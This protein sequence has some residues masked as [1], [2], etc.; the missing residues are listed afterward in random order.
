MTAAS[1]VG[2]PAPPA[3]QPARIQFRRRSVVARMPLRSKVALAVLGLV[4]VAAVCAPVLP[5]D[6]P[7]AGELADRLRNF[8]A[9][10]HPLGTDTQGRDMVSRL[11]Y[12]TRTSLFAGVAP[13]VIA[14]VLGLVWGTL[15]ALA[16]RI[17]NTV[18]MRALDVLFAFPGV[19][20]SL[21]LAIK[22]G[23]GVR[24]L[25][26]ALTLVWIAPVARIAETEVI[27][28][29][30]LD[31]MAAARSSGASFAAIL[32]RQVI[33]VALPAIVAYSTSLVGANIAIT[34]GLG[35]IGLGV[36]TPTPELGSML[37]E[38]QGQIYAHPTLSLAPVVV[39]LALS[40]LFP[41]VGDG[42]RDAI[43]GRGGDS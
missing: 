19:L 41:I 9:P 7:L 8:G 16:G 3:A 10:G 43:A 1:V 31:F 28:I 13:I 35:F 26:I 14:T 11:V 20:L 22:L 38:M 17:V 24:T 15:A 39:V 2:A 34:G 29:K 36:R 42:L 18:M 4:V 27:R 21:L 5:L 40:I 25:I 12:G 23:V 33:P 6:D 37:Q 30:D 32:V